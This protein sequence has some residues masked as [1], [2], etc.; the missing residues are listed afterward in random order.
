[1]QKRRIKIVKAVWVM[2][3][4]RDPKLDYLLPAVRAQELYEQGRLG[5]CYEEEKYLSSSGEIHH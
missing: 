5:W 4:V 3:D 1:M 2:R